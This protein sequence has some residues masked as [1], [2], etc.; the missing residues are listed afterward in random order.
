MGFGR[1]W[2]EWISALLASANSSVLVNGVRGASFKHRN[3]LRQG[4]PLSPMLFILAM[5]PLQRMLQLA[6]QAGLLRPIN[7]TAKLRISMYADDAAIFANPDSNEMQAIQ[8]ILEI[9]GE[10]TGLKINLAKCAAYPIQCHGID[11]QEVM[12]HLPCEIK[13]FPCTYLGL[14]LSI[15]KLKKADVRPWWTK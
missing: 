6:T 9:F 2:R 5:E 4:D 13:S 7:N 10:V 12:Q 14:P 8:Q 1:R 3:G 15:R 11:L